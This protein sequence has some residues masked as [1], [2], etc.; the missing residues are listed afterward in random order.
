M[1]SL[2]LYKNFILDYFIIIFKNYSFL[3]T[4]EF[5]FSNSHVIGY[6]EIIECIFLIILFT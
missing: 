6:S 3:Y 5:L 2:Q 1:L 4:F